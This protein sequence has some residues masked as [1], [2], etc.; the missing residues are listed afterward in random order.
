MILFK[1]IKGFIKGLYFELLLWLDSNGI[2]VGSSQ[3]DDKWLNGYKMRNESI[4]AMLNVKE[5]LYLEGVGKIKDKIKALANSKTP[6]AYR[7]ALTSV[8]NLI[9]LAI[10]EDPEKLKTLNAL[11]A[12]LKVELERDIVTPLD[13]AKMLKRRVKD[14][15][16]SNKRREKRR[17]Q[18]KIRQVEHSGNKE[19]LSILM[20]EWQEKY[21]KRSK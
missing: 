8:E 13:H 4:K 9:D 10:E 1:Q 5:I 19:Q 17:L 7:K 3:Y 21:G 11:R 2:N 14:L 20:Q 12:A 6:E 15:E 18:R 16:E